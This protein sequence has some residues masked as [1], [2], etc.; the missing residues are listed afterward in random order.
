MKPGIACSTCRFCEIWKPS[1][2]LPDSPRELL[3]CRR[4][5]PQNLEGDWIFPEVSRSTWCGE[6]E[7]HFSPPYSYAE[8]SRRWGRDR[9]SD[10]GT[11]GRE[12]AQGSGDSSRSLGA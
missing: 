5:P 11:H 4:R 3:E 1:I 8:H 10:R 6:W 2:P 7:G 9:E 12:L